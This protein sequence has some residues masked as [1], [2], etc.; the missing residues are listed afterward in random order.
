ME[1]T[2]ENIDVSVL[3]AA[4][5][6]LEEIAN[7][8]REVESMR[9]GYSVREALMRQLRAKEEQIISALHLDDDARNKGD[10][11]Q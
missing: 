5:R 10:S 2:E 1:K 3:L 4:G 8:E 7:A 9:L 6:D 11:E